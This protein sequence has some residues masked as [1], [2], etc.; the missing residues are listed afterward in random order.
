MVEEKE[1]NRRV[2]DKEL[3]HN[4]KA[5]ELRKK[6]ADFRR[7]LRNIVATNNNA[8]NVSDVNNANNSNDNDNINDNDNVYSDVE[9]S[10]E[11]AAKRRDQDM[12]RILKS[13]GYKVT[14]KAE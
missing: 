4:Q 12:I 6:D 5:E 13:R 2:E 9:R 10:Q 3:E 7:G 11:I 8:G 14:K 1:Q